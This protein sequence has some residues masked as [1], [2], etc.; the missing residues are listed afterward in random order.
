[1]SESQSSEPDNQGTPGEFSWIRRVLRGWQGK[2]NSIPLLGMRSEPWFGRLGSLAILALVFLGIGG[3]LR[4]GAMAAGWAYV[5]YPLPR[6]PEAWVN[7]SV[8]AV[9][10]ALLAI[11]IA[12]LVSRLEPQKPSRGKFS[13]RMWRLSHALIMAV[14]AATVFEYLVFAA[15]GGGP[16]WPWD[17]VQKLNEGSGSSLVQPALA[18]ITP[19]IAFITAVFAYRRARLSLAESW[20][21]DAAGYQQRFV[22]ASTLLA[23]NNS[24]ARIAGAIALGNLARDSADLRQQ[25][26][27]VICG[28][29]R[30]KP[31]EEHLGEE[32]QQTEGEGSENKV[33]YVWKAGEDSVRNQLVT[34]LS[35]I[36]I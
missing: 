27:D 26:V 16:T 24:S 8:L 2:A 21:S 32:P 36:H 34:E 35:L 5:Q 22:E 25:C 11:F 12:L 30:T 10:T 31:S 13:P 3:L 17:Q 23:H 18:L 29:L 19:Y 15:L 1:M 9:I 20:R 14:V 7:V 4:L 28:Y 33:K 6:H